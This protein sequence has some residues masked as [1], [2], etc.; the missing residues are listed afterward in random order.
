MRNS[1][2]LVVAAHP[3]D[4]VLGCGGTMALLSAKNE[5]YTLILGT[6]ITS[7]SI[8]EKEKKENLKRIKGDA[9]RANKV[10][11]VSEV[12]LEDFPD[13]K[14]DS[15][16]LLDIVKTIEEKI[17]EIKPT[18]IFTHHYGDLNIDHRITFDAV[19]AAARPIE[20]CPV[21]KIY[22]FEVLSS[23]EWNVQD[24]KRIFTPNTYY[25]I[26]ETIQQK[27]ESMKQYKS[28][29]KQYPHPRSVEGIRIHAQKRGLEVGLEYAEAF[30]LIRHIE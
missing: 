12:F 24:A 30:N 13:N 21:R 7:R 18:I 26:S 8:P 15:V 1:R 23:S 22:T 3:D 14:F 19:L 4:E 28:E 17:R 10:L 6:G 16:S 11:G 9:Y 20:G 25:N 5:V 2:I 27:L 29:I